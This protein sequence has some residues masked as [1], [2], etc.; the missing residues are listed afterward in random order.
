MERKLGTEIATTFS[1]R[2][3]RLYAPEVEGLPPQMVACLERLK[4]AE[5]RNANEGDG[6][7]SSSSATR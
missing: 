1:A 6:R 2:L 5:Q 4:R 7:G 3:K